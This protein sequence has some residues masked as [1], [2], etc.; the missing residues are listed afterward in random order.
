[1]ETVKGQG[2]LSWPERK[3][4]RFT[5]EAIFGIMYL[6]DF[7]WRSCLSWIT[8]NLRNI[9]IISWIWNYGSVRWL[10]VAHLLINNVLICSLRMIFSGSVTSSHLA[11]KIMTTS[12]KESWNYLQSLE[13][14]YHIQK[15]FHPIL[16]ENYLA[17]FGVF[18]PSPCFHAQI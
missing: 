6:D 10:I 3:L 15:V 12:L 17:I 9:I 11:N 2:E 7:A 18:Y 4:V 5:T 1:M 8:W 14:M 13:E 16:V